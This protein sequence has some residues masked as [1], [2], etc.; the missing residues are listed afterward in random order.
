MQKYIEYCLK[1]YFATEKKQYKIK[2]N[3][4][5]FAKNFSFKLIK[6]KNFHTFI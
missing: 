6:F 2:S 1:K 3:L 5:T 4:I